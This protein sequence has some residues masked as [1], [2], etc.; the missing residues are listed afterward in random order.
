MHKSQQQLTNQWSTDTMDPPLIIDDRYLMDN[1]A[2][3]LSFINRNAKAMGSFGRPRKFFLQYVMNYLNNLAVMSMDKVNSKASTQNA[4]KQQVN[5]L[6][7]S[8]LGKHR[9]SRRN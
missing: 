8:A 6:Y 9:N 3:S 7:E 5:K 1:L 4:V 2:L